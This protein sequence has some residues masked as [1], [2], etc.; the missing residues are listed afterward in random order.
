MTFPSPDRN[1]FVKKKPS[2]A[3]I[4]KVYNDFAFRKV[5][6]CRAGEIRLF[7][8]R[9]NGCAVRGIFENRL[10][11]EF[12]IFQRNIDKNVFVAIKF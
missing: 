5:G 9:L 10:F 4:E 7:P 12:K 6:Y 1:L 3:C 2:N 8:G 11:A